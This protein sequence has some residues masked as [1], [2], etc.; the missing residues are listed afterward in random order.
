[1]SSRL[2]VNSIRHTGASSDALTL[3]SSGNVTCNGT[4]TGF[5]GGKT[6]QVVN[7]IKTNTFSGQSISNALVDITGL[8]LSITPSSSSNKILIEFNVC[9]GSNNGCRNGIILSRSIGG[10][11]YSVVTQADADGNR[12]RMTTIGSAASQYIPQYQSISILDSPNTTSAITYKIQVWAESNCTFK[13][14]RIH[15]DSDNAAYGNG[16]STITATEVAS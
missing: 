4:A 10:G 7:T 5:G 2:I 11:S 13:I 16:C 3:D 9:M 14:N 15:T 8:T 12:Q 6:L 1:M